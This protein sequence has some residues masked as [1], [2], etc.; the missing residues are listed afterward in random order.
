MEDSDELGA[1]MGRERDALDVAIARDGRALERFAAAVLGRSAESLGAVEQAF[2][3]ASSAS[4]DAEEPLARP[5][6]FG[7]LRRRVAQLEQR[8]RAEEGHASALPGL[9]LE[10]VRPTEREA[11]LLR[12]VSGLSVQDVALAA[13]IDEDAARTRISRGLAFVARLSADSAET[14]ASPELAAQRRGVEEALA[15]VVDGLA[16]DAVTD[17]V[18]GDDPS[19]DLVHAAE[20]IVEKLRGFDGDVPEDAELTRR[21]RAAV[22]AARVAQAAPSSAVTK[23]IA[24]EPGDETAATASNDEKSVPPTGSAAKGTQP[25]IA[26]KEH[27]SA[28]SAAGGD[29]RRARRRRLAIAATVAA[30][31]GALAI[32]VSR[33][34]AGVADA[35]WSGKV[36]TVSRAFGGGVGVERCSPDRAVCGRVDEGDDIPAGSTLRTDGQTRAV[37]EMRDGT[38][39][40]LDRDSELLLDGTYARRAR[41]DHGSLV[42]DVP[43]LGNSRARFDLP[44]GFVETESVKVSLTADSSRADAEVAR[45][46][47]RLADA[48]ER[49]VAVHAGEVGRLEPD[50]TPEVF[51][52]FSMGDRFDWTER[53]FTKQAPEETI[54]GLG[55]LGAKKPGDDHEKKGLVS[56]TSHST[57]VRIVGNVARTEIEEEFTSS[58]DDV[59][60]GVFRFPLPP[61]AQIERLALDVDGKIEEGAFVDRDRASAIWRGAIVNAGA[62]KPAEE[63]IVWVPGP[64]RDPALLEWQRGGRFE[65]RIYPIPKRAS[66]KVLLSYTQAISPSGGL[67]RY[68]YPLPYDP[69]GSTRIG[70][71]DVDVEIRGSDP[72][73]GIVA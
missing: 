57:R 33:S 45:G 30:A 18:A 40:V 53:A 66:R 68:V 8:H 49:S 60:E 51:A 73:A 39:V 34:N 15:G 56:L 29:E 3:Q 55:E 46:S 64:W 26:E 41:L 67:R 19:R 61:D 71:F 6:L 12:Y 38:R 16:L 59:L 20:R 21:I 4:G 7:I 35:A 70:R 42:A 27:A 36:G 24:P 22:D 17:F 65:L 37:V 13:S 28:P 5:R 31:L 32:V 10:D 44:L 63:E 48:N 72:R 62:K 47:V 54:R 69:A 52:S 2:A 14:A 50:R 25:K 9:G 11:L 23:D 58:S 43:P 1:G